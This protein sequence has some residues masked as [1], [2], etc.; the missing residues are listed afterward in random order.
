MKKLFFPLLS[1]FALLSLS[2][3]TKLDRTKNTTKAK[4]QNY[5]I[6]GTLRNVKSDWIYIAS[7]DSNKRFS[8]ID[9]A[10]VI[11]EKFIFTGHIS[12]PKKYYIGMRYVNKQGKR[13][14][15]GFQGNFMLDSGTLTIDCHKDSIVNL[16]ASGTVAQDQLNQFRQKTASIS[17]EG[18][19]LYGAQL[20]A[21][22]KQDKKLLLSLNNLSKQ[23]RAA[24]NNVI[25]AHVK[26]YPFYL[27]TA[28][29]T[30]EYINSI[31]LNNLQTIY[32]LFH[33]NLKKSSYANAILKKI[34][35]E[36]STAI[37]NYAP[38]FELP[39]PTG[40]II[41]LTSYKGKITLIDFW[42]SWCGPC[43]AEN[44]NLIRAYT[45]FKAK[46]FDILSISMDSSKE[47]W[48]NAI[49][50]DKLPWLQLSDLK[51]G[52]SDLKALYGITSIPMNF[53]LD[54][55]G[56]IIAKNLRGIEIEQILNK[57]FN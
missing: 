49:K 23:N 45:Q 4:E 55:N 34:T 1:I 51:A 13:S 18:N 11:D 12:E 46:G 35:I 9:S 28:I 27:T 43:R 6:Y 39:T 41:P 32:N 20:N 56:K 48:L 31:E 40:K 7:Y 10:Q 26:L 5:T 44:P 57:Q 50:E 25:L 22:K 14:G 17:K 19:R 16:R 42:A 29:I 15:L 30:E 3:T 21:E 38:T 54:K 53:L 47:N 2:L 36:N 33:E 37:G 8:Q 52:K 24:L